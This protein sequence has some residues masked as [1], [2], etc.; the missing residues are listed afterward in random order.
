M[1]VAIKTTQVAVKHPLAK[2]W[3]LEDINLNL[4]SGKVYGLMGANGSGKTT[5]CNTL[6]GLIP[7]VLGGEVKGKIEIFG[8]D[9]NGL[10]QRELV[11]TIALVFEN[12]YTQLTGTCQTVVEEIAFGLENLGWE[13]ER[14][15]EQT[16]RVI[17]DMDLQ[18]LAFRDPLELSGGQRQRVS[19]AAVMAMDT[20]VIVIDEPTSQLD[21]ATT[22]MIFAAITK[23]KDA[24]KTVLLCE[25][26]IDQLVEIADEIIILDNGRV[27]TAGQPGE[28]LSRAKSD[29]LHCGFPE[30]FTL[31]SGLNVSPRWITFAQAKASVNT[32]VEE[33]Q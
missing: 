22:E 23:M 19:V 26:K 20:P 8:K 2:T 6:K 31:S 11:E 24:G 9:L 13:R 15:I 25:N 18:D 16:A 4:E 3:A 17:C 27:Y 5:L 12:P 10:S 7:G 1:V 32:Y 33:W 14:I 30:L 21:P 29:G 28:V